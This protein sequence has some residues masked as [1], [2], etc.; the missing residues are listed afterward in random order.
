L[1]I[2]ASV[3]MYVIVVALH[4][5]IVNNYSHALTPSPTWPTTVP[6]EEL[7]PRSTTPPS[8]AHELGALDF[9]LWRHVGEAGEFMV[10]S[11]INNWI[12]CAEGTGSLVGWVSGTI[13]CRLVKSIT[14]ICPQL[15]GEDMNLVAYST[16]VLIR[17]GSGMYYALLGSTANHWPVHDPCG[18]SS[19]DNCLKGVW[20]KGQVWLR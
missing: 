9:S 15:P 13:A 18:S 7:T 2:Y 6:V 8:D 5:E 12:A 16:G 20:P 14:V 1:L 17:W 11:N 4:A 19:L 10:K 3:L